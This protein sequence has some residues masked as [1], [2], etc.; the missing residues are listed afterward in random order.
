M[1]LVDS[2][3][4]IWGAD[5]PR[6]PWPRGGAAAAHRI[7]PVGIRE[8]L[9]VLDAAGVSRAVLV[10]PSWEGD[11]NDIALAAARRHPH[12][13]AVM[14]RVGLRDR[15]SVQRIAR[16]WQRPESL[17]LRLT[18]HRDPWRTALLSGALD[19]LWSAAEDARLPV[20]VYPP[21]LCPEIGRVAD[22]HPGLRIVIDHMAMP[23]GTAGANAFTHL[24]DLLS[25]A[26]LPNV[27]V[28]ASAL[29]CHSRLE[30]PFAD[31]HEPLRR[32]FDAFGPDRLFWGSDWT[33]LPC[34]YRAN[35]A[36][37]TSAVDFFSGPDLRRV[38]GE[39]L[40][41]WL[42]WPLF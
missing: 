3:V 25:L 40:L 11:R 28:K 1:M 39:A 31:V 37:F 29:P 35:I 10:P 22:R 5:S 4:H 41:D 15:W 36:L 32:V 17:G 9:S 30:F 34:T 27:A 33:R 21:G 26:R 38:M 14:C 8:T 12:R 16:W 6:R 13:F 20:M 24:P 18:L 23:L 7:R 2:Q 42:D 19:R